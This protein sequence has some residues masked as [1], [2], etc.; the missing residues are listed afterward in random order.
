MTAIRG[1]IYGKRFTMYVLLILDFLYKNHDQRMHFETLSVE[2][3]LPRNPADDS[4]WVTDFSKEEMEEWANKLGNL[5]IITRRKNSSQNRKDYKIKKQKYF[6]KNIDTCPNSLRVL[7]KYDQWTLKEL[8]ENHEE[9]LRKL[10]EY[11]SL[12]LL[13]GTS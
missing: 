5:V 6:E 9:V 12:E 8:T 3:I 4:D 10:S 11:Y 13:K 7:N 2:H 1:N